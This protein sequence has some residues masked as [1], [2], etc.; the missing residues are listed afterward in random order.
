MRAR[1][2]TL[3]AA[4]PPRCPRPESS[5][6]A[7]PPPA[8]LY[9]SL[10]PDTLPEADCVRSGEGEHHPVA[11]RR[12]VHAQRTLERCREDFRIRPAC[13]R[14]LAHIAALD[15]APHHRRARRASSTACTSSTARVARSPPRRRKVHR[16]RR[17][18]RSLR[19]PTG[20]DIVPES[21][22]LVA[23]P[24]PC[25]A[26]RR[27]GTAQDTGQGRA[28]WSALGAASV[29]R[30]HRTHPTPAG[31]GTCRSRERS[32]C[33]AD[34]TR[35]RVV[36]FASPAGG[37]CGEAGDLDAAT[38]GTA[39]GTLEMSLLQGPDFPQLFSEKWLP[40]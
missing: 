15:H 19:T 27:R 23:R 17:H 29:G 31:R 18:D 26:A 4:Q 34:A 37:F 11:V 32:G 9:G 8:G 1:P 39:R 33:V 10:S 5:V 35:T 36:P 22:V 30:S 2:A 25:G 28:T 20:T 7:A 21:C 40:E 3:G 16:R 14:H 12:R 6:R 24:V 13:L 38:G